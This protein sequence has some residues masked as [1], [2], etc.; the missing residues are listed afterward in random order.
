MG[1]TN[2]MAIA[3]HGSTIDIYVNKMLVA[4]LTNTTFSVGRIGVM[5]VDFSSVPVNVAFSNAQIW[6]I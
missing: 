3:A 4:T 2:L 5:G 6:L 1:Q